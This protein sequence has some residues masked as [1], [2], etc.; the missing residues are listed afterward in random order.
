MALQTVRAITARQTT[1]G[2]AE[3][4]LQLSLDGAAAANQIAVA[5]GTTYYLTDV[6][7]TGAAAAE[8]RVQQT[9]DGVAWFDLTTLYIAA[10]GMAGVDFRTPPKITGGAAVA[11]RTRVTTAGGAAAVTATI[12]G[13]S[14]A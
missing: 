3:E 8:L 6:M 14:E 5:A 7:L 12:R 1:A 4:T 10:T 9:N 11:F 2:A 13:Y